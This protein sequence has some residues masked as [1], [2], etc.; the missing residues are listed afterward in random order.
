MSKSQQRKSEISIGAKP[1]RATNSK[2]DENADSD[3][4]CGQLTARVER[5]QTQILKPSFS[6]IQEKKPKI[7]IRQPKNRA[8]Q[9]YVEP[10][11]LKLKTE[12]LAQPKVMDLTCSSGQY[13]KHVDN[14]NALLQKLLVTKSVD[15]QEDSASAR[16]RQRSP[17]APHF[18]RKGF[19]KSP[20]TT[21]T[22]TTEHISIDDA[23]TVFDDMSSGSDSQ[24]SSKAQSIDSA[25]NVLEQQRIQRQET[26]VQRKQQAIESLT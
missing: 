12:H 3:C 19:R 4:K 6:Y 7:V 17:R 25:E 16:N 24:Y 14:K 2:T 9:E 11:P 18:G 20:S 1:E 23:D 10:A 5:T 8:K 26:F 22:D 21:Q 15:Q 13:A